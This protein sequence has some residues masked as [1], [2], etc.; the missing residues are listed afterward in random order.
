[1]RYRDLTTDRWSP[2][3]DVGYGIGVGAVIF[4]VIGRFDDDDHLGLVRRFSTIDLARD[5][6]RRMKAAGYQRVGAWALTEVRGALGTE[7]KYERIE[8]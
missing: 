2:P 7:L 3:A 4:I 6:A 8:M 1:M 5:E